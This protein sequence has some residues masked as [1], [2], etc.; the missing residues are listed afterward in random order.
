MKDVVDEGLLN[1]VLHVL[2]NYENLIILILVC[3]W[4]ELMFTDSNSTKQKCTLGKYGSI[5][6]FSRDGKV[7][8][9]Y[10]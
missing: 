5:V 9:N 4:D 7:C 2:E 10:F 3:H 6:S 8:L 1:N